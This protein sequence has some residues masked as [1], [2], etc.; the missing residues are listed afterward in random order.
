MK[1]QSFQQKFR[2]L[3]IGPLNHVELCLVKHDE[4]DVDGR[5]TVEEEE[6]IR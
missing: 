4:D 2:K 5:D 6:K 1:I 3:L